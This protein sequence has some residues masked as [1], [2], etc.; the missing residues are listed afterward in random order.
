M[1]TEEMGV[2]K[3]KEEG[4]TRYVVGQ[5]GLG[6]RDLPDHLQHVPGSRLH[7]PIRQ[8]LWGWQ[9]SWRRDEGHGSEAG[10][11]DNAWLIGLNNIGGHAKKAG[12]ERT[13]LTT[14]EVPRT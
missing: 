12:R 3:E 1:A 8:D 14:L 10:P 6:E 9:G 5:T 4:S 7:Q 13:V 11:E 2:G